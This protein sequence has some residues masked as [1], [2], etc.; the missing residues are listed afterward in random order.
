M[1]R[2]KSNYDLEQMRV[3]AK[4]AAQIVEELGKM[5]VP[6]ANADQLESR[7]RELCRQHGVEPNFL[8]YQGYEFATCIS[9]NEEAVHAFPLESKVFREGDLVSVDFGTRY[10]GYN[11]DH[12]RTFAAGKASPIHQ[13]LLQVGEDAVEQA[14]LQATRGK[15]IGDISA[16]MQQTAEEAGFSIVKQYI[17]HGIGKKLHEWPEVPAFGEP[18]EGPA[19]EP[20]MVICVECQVCEGSGE[21]THTNDGWTAITKD[22]GYA[23][24]FEHMVRITEGKPEVLTRL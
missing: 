15:H 6:G 23:V 2:T 10:R 18:G 16:A 1:S 4:A 8:G 9:V 7:A 5:V 21:L 19:L 12:C 17:G 24:M 14:I 13:K 22:G 3:A 11:S 20:N